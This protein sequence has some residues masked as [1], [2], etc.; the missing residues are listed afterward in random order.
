MINRNKEREGH[1]REFLLEISERHNPNRLNSVTTSVLYVL[2]RSGHH[3][4]MLWLKHSMI[5]RTGKM[6]GI[7]RDGKDL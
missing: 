1:F 7:L 2:R 3:L 5:R 4:L 6:G